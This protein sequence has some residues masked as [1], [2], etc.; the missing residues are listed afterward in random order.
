MS[1]GSWSMDDV[2]LGLLASPNTKITYRPNNK[3]KIMNGGTKGHGFFPLANGIL[4][5]RL[6]Y[7]VKKPWKEYFVRMWFVLFPFFLASLSFH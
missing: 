7:N 1:F 2:G 6:G 5:V 3:G 4:K